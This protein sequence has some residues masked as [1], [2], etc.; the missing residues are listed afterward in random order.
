MSL[1]LTTYEPVMSHG[2]HGVGSDAS[3]VDTQ[4]SKIHQE[5]L[6]LATNKIND[7]DL[8]KEIQGI[9]VETSEPDWDGYGALPLQSGSLRYALVFLWLLPSQYGLPMIDADNKGRISFEWIKSK[10]KRLSVSV[11]S[12]GK[13]IYAFL[14]GASSGSGEE[15]LGSTVPDTILSIIRRIS[16]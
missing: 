8:Q 1:A 4:L 12:S 16:E 3:Y 5:A 9:I 15:Y 13:L 6:N 11:T 14:A 2:S 10:S 7:L